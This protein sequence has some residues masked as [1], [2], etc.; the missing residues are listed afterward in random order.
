MIR[1]GRQAQATLTQAIDLFNED[2][3]DDALPLFEQ[4]LEWYQDQKDAENEAIVHFFIGQILAAGDDIEAA[5]SEITTAHSLFR[6]LGDDVGRARMRLELGELAYWEQH[7]DIATRHFGRVVELL[8]DANAEDVL[9]MAHARLGAI[10][11]EQENVGTAQEHYTAALNLYDR[12][13]DTFSAANTLIELASAIQEE[14]PA[15]ARRLFERGRDLAQSAGSDYLASMALHGLGVLHADAEEWGDAVQSY[16]IALE[17]KQRCDDHEGEIFTLLAL[18]AAQQE[19]GHEHTARQ[20]WKK[21]LR[22]AREQD[23]GDVANVA[24]TLLEGDDVDI[25]Y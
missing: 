6:D 15:R 7:Y 21:A 8:T 12:T 2:N 20:S 22:L 10:F 17:L 14:E 4:S 19:L 5:R 24:R 16:K 9:A 13:G 23:L 11:T 1:D 25:D 18:G 3:L